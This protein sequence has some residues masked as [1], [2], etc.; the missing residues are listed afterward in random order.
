[1]C[2]DWTGECACL[3]TIMTMS[4]LCLK[5]SWSSA[6]QNGH[7][8]CVIAITDTRDDPQAH[9]VFRKEPGSMKPPLSCTATLASP[10]FCLSSQ[11][12][13]LKPKST[14]VARIVA[15]LASKSKSSEDVRVSIPEICPGQ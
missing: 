9:N 3:V 2:G 11:S 1:M 13:L 5:D 10:R 4:I 7:D 6:N 12:R 15:F 8:A 14:F